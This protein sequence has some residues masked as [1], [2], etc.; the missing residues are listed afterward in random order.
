MNLLRL[1]ANNNDLR[2]PLS[3]DLKYTL[4]AAGRLARYPASLRSLLGG[5]DALNKLLMDLYARNPVALVHTHGFD[6]FLDPADLGFSPSIGVLGF[7]ELKTTELF[8]K[9]VEGGSTVIDVG[10][11][12]GFFTLLAAKLAGKEGVVL[13]FE[14]DPTS[15]ALLSKS[16]QRNNFGN[17]RLFQK[18]ISDVD[19]EQILY[20]SVTHHKGMH[21]I[22]RNLGGRRINVK[23]A[24][25]DTVAD[26]LNIGEID[27]LK[28]DV[29]GAEPEVLDG[30]TRLL[31]EHRVR[32]I[33]M[34]W[35]H[36]EVW[37]RRKD[38]FDMVFQRFDVY[39]FARSIPFL[40]PRRLDSHSASPFS[41]SVGT[42]VYL[43]RHS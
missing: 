29:E 24:R 16:V 30:A 25:L 23:S 21:S 22:S 4:R 2:V 32:N 18:C 14:P 5:A 9:L 39:R 3:L 43:R 41:T 42:N 36:P 13:S 40:S 33:I 6:I 34:E 15:F 26:S 37:A 10:A 11:N 12:V 35:E 17:V 38:I 8:I 19:G 20:L 27:L 1:L 28:I 7:Y 31:S